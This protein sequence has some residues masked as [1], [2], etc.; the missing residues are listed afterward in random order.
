MSGITIQEYNKYNLKQPN[1]NLNTHFA[2][3]FLL[4]HIFAD[5]KKVNK[6]VNL[7]DIIYLWAL[8]CVGTL[9]YFK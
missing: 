2:F 7:Y 4:K 9:K 6:S 5:F 8:R 3:V 1:F